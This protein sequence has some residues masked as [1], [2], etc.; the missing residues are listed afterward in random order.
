MNSSMCDDFNEAGSTPPINLVLTVATVFI[1]GLLVHC[2]ARA[3]LAKDIKKNPNLVKKLL[4][5]LCVVD[6]LGILSATAYQVV[7]VFIPEPS[8]SACVAI[9]F[10]NGFL[11]QASNALATIMAV[12]RCFAF[13]V[14]YWYIAN[15]HSWK[16]KVPI[17]FIVI[18][19][20][21]V[22]MLP[23]F[24]FGLVM[25]PEK[26][27]L[28]KMLPSVPISPTSRLSVYTIVYASVGLMFV[29]V[30]I[31]CN[32]VVIASLF[33][34]VHKRAPPKQKSILAEYEMTIMLLLLSVNFLISWIPFYVSVFLN[35]FGKRIPKTVSFCVRVLA[36][37]SYSTDPLIYIA[38]RKSYRDRIRTR[39]LTVCG[40]DISSE[41]T[42][43]VIT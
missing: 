30:N 35:Y 18:C 6:V 23:A 10:F 15:I 26:P 38:A 12:E 20:I 16:L 39:I 5:A 29:A 32:I 37:V 43:S 21:V 2:V 14:T 42:V 8:Y 36:G 27:K 34:M 1:P 9:G 3:L 40:N 7:N 13:S 25:D 4:G 28:C 33:R 24:G 22:N 19:L 11:S 41:K 17:P 31:V